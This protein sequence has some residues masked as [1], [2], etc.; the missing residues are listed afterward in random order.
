VI[1]QASQ[2][3]AE[4]KSVHLLVELLF[5]IVQEAVGKVTHEERVYHLEERETDTVKVM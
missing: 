4:E 2:V 5:Q 3:W 1:S